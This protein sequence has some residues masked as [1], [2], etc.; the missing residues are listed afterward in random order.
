MLM[1]NDP[2][3]KPHEDIDFTKNPDIKDIATNRFADPQ[4]QA[5]ASQHHVSEYSKLKYGPAGLGRYV[6]LSVLEPETFKEL[7]TRQQI[8][9]SNTKAWWYSQKPPETTSPV[10][11]GPS[12]PKPSESESEGLAQQLSAAMDEQLPQTVLE[13]RP[14]RSLSI[15]TQ[16]HTIKT[17]ASHPINISAIVPP[18]ILSIISS[19]LMFTSAGVSKELNESTV[20]ILDTQPTVFEVPAPFTLDHFILSPSLHHLTP[21]LRNSIPPPPIPVETPLSPHL[22]TRSHVTEALHAAINSGMKPDSTFHSNGSSVSL[23]ISVKPITPS[24]PLKRTMSEPE[25]E[26]GTVVEPI[27]LPSEASET[28]PPTNAELE[29][30]AQLPS[31][32]STSSPSQS[33]AAP[34]FLLGNL[35]LSSCPGK[36]VR[37][38]GPVKGRSGVCRDLSTDL[39]RM[40]DLGVGCVVCC[41]DDTELE[42]LGAP[43]PEYQSAAS[44]IGLDVLRLPTPEGLAPSLSP[45]LLDK[46]LTTL[47]QNYTLR[48]IPVLVHCRGGVG[49]AGVISACWISKLGLCG[50]LGDVS[51]PVT[52]TSKSLSSTTLSDAAPEK[53]QNLINQDALELVEKVIAVVRRR[54]SVKAIETFEQAQFL[55]DFIEHLR[56]KTALPS[57]G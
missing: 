2:L 33:T 18:E 21:A 31:L 40:K 43:W 13:E 51:S 46:E 30:E 29:A 37:L 16:N 47:I 1:H 25:L 3:P 28:G 10:I 6:P 57:R 44:K 5:L 32:E 50:W 20:P 17:S 19:H 27:D 8:H 22:R 48:G 49:R 39:Q 7:R 36:K 34:S 42:F 45:D 52:S 38:Q 26:S 24:Q 41:L 35:F 54:R 23:S 12:A 15:G 14:V 9:C 53:T 56:L 55:I 4:V 11:L